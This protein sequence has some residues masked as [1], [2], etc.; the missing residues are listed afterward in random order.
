M[1][2]DAASARPSS[3]C[4]DYLHPLVEGLVGNAHAEYIVGRVSKGELT[5]S[6]LISLVE[7]CVGDAA[8]PLGL[9]H[10]VSGAYRGANYK[11]AELGREKVSVQS[12]SQAA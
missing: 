10:D 11:S 12:A 5:V 7:G 8:F 2:A 9:P 4:L 3:I 6:S 1:A